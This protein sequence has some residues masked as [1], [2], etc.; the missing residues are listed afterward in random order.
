MERLSEK[1]MRFV[2]TFLREDGNPFDVGHTQERRSRFEFR[3]T[4]IDGVHQ[5]MDP[6][7]YQA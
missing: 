2:V 7:P 4:M 5:V 6:P 3:V 1:E